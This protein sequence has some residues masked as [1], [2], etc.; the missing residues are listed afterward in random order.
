MAVTV[1]SLTEDV[2]SYRTCMSSADQIEAVERVTELL[3]EVSDRIKQDNIAAWGRAITDANGLL[4]CSYI[5]LEY[6]AFQTLPNGL[7]CTNQG[8]QCVP[9]QNGR[10]N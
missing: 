9:L 2:E 1:A 8:N 7:I 5:P 6:C 4:D 10:R 3:T